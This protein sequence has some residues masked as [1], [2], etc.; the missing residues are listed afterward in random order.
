MRGIRG[1]GVIDDCASWVEFGRRLA[2]DVRV[3]P[4]IPGLRFQDQWQNHVIVD[5]RAELQL[6]R[7]AS[8]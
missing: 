3:M 8:G 1:D 7:L 5:D 4:M 6:H 2:W